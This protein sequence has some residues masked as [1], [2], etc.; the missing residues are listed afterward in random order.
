MSFLKLSEY[1]LYEK[2]GWLDDN[3]GSYDTLD[4][5]LLGLQR[6]GTLFESLIAEAERAGGE[7][8]DLDDPMA[9]Y[10]EGNSVY[11]AVQYLDS[12]AHVEDVVDNLLVEH[13]LH[14]IESP[15]GFSSY[16]DF[17]AWR[18]S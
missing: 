10:L 4:S 18:N 2:V 6:S 14:E 8:C 11:D 1:T 12:Q 3:I 17:C 13:G 16:N 9:W 7:D 15:D 5:I